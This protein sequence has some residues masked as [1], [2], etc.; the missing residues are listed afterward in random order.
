MV[1]KNINVY[2]RQ[3]LKLADEF[4]VAVVVTNQVNRIF[5]LVLF[6]EGQFHHILDNITVL[7][8]FQGFLHNVSVMIF[9]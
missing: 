8:T 3:L 1:L 9:L 2:Y 7:E 5:F 4:G 6:I